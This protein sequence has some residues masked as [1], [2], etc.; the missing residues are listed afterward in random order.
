MSTMGGV[1]FRA[2]GT[3][4]RLSIVEMFVMKLARWSFLFLLMSGVVVAQDIKIVGSIDQIINLPSSGNRLKRAMPDVRHITLLKVELSEKA[5]QKI[6]SRADDALNKNKEMSAEPTE[7]PTKIQLGMG[8]VPVLDQG[9]HGSCVAFSV[10]GAVNAALKKGDYI[11]QLCLLQLGNHIE[12]NGYVPSGW[13]GSLGGMV[14]NQLN[15]YGIVSRSQQKA[16]GCGGLK[17]YP[18]RGTDPSTE[19][20]PE[21]YHQISEPLDPNIV[22]WTHLLDIYQVFLDKT[23]TNDTIIQV[24][25]ALNE[26]DRVTFGVLLPDMD[27]G[28]V[29]A[30]GKYNAAFDSWILTPEIASGLKTRQIEAGHDLIITG[31]DDDAVAVDQQGRKYQGLFTLRNSW[32]KS[33]GDK[34]NFYMSYDYFKTLVSEVQRIRRLPA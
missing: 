14:L 21:E 10:T 9:S 26:G 6:D 29:G 1:Y 2:H 12:K 15:E 13:N 23:N 20:T 34:G 30:V 19:M 7:Y 17:E 32:G 11:S 28:V 16:I 25:E 8:A 18:I 24:K 27:L 4:T 3:L 22:G 5:M 33:V 31:Y